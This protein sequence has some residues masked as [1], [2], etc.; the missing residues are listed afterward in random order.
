MVGWRGGSGQHKGNMESFNSVTYV[1]KV[2][3]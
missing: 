2:K 1:N 3:A